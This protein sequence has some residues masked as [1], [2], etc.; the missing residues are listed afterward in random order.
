LTVNQLGTLEH[1][2]RRNGLKIE[3]LAISQLS[4]ADQI[5]RGLPG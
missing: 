3:V 2:C 4:A 5:Y 1:N